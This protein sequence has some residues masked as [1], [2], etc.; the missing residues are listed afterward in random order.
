MGWTKRSEIL[1][2]S[3]Y[4]KKVVINGKCCGE[5]KAP[6]EYMY[7]MIFP[8]HD[9]REEVRRDDI[10]LD[11]PVKYGVSVFFQKRGEPMFGNDGIAIT[12][13]PKTGEYHVNPINYG[14]LNGG[15]RQEG[16]HCGIYGIYKD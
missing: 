12:M 14:Q 10:V 16:C 5:F 7:S 15:Q 13:D 1:F 2:R 4:V 6:I 8:G 3:L 11:H 9:Y